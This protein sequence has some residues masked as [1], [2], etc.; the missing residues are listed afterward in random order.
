MVWIRS[1]VYNT[2]ETDGRDLRQDLVIIEKRIWED[3]RRLW[4]QALSSFIKNDLVISLPKWRRKLPWLRFSVIHIKLQIPS[5]LIHRDH[6]KTYRFKATN[7]NFGKA[8]PAETVHVS[9]GSSFF[10]SF[11]NAVCNYWIRSTI[12]SYRSRTQC[13]FLSKCTQFKQLGVLQSQLEFLAAYS[14]ETGS[15]LLQ[16]SATSW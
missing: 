4:V 11:Y 1:F 3:W 6:F 8:K 9:A 16:A 10:L 15:Y 12:W 5:V 7:P 2:D 14:L 13:S